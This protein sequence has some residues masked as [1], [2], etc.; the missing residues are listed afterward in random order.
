MGIADLRELAVTSPI[1]VAELGGTTGAVDAFNW[2]YRYMT[3]TVR[4]TDPEEYTTR[5]GT[6]VPNLIGITRGLPRFFESRFFPVFV[7]DGTPTSLKQK[8]L[9]ERR[10]RRQEAAAQAEAARKRGE[11]RDAAQY[12]ARAQ[13]ITRP[14]RR[15]TEELLELLDLPFFEAPSE[16]EAQAAH[17]ARTDHVDYAVTDDY[18]VL[19]YGAPR[20]IREFTSEGPPECMDLEATLDKHEITWEQ[21]VDVAI[22]CGTDY[23]EGIR[24]IG[25]TGALAEIKQH[26]DLET[27]LARLDETIE[28]ADRIRDLFLHPGVTDEYEFEPTCTPDLC[29]ARSFLVDEWEIPESAISRAFE[30]LEANRDVWASR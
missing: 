11:M 1:D 21:L 10:A 9:V 4:Y 12:Q 25:P 19:V 2:L 13:R 22:L 16:A 3:I 14:I 18:D 26:G 20:T 24:G 28:N 17:M 8:E 27:V 5:E 29:A 30:R 6:E 23:N 7:F 15:T